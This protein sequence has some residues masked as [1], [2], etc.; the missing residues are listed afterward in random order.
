MYRAKPF[1]AWNGKL[2]E[3]ELR[4][5]VRLMSQMGFGGFFMHSRCGLD[6]KY[7]SEEW[8]KCINACVDEAE[9][10]DMQAWLYDEDR[11]P[12][13][14]AGGLVTKNPEYRQ[15]HLK[16][17][18]FHDN[19]AFTWSG[20]T[21][22]VFK[23]GL[24]GKKAS[25]I[26]RLT[27]KSLTETL[28]KGEA[29]LVFSV[30]ISEPS[31]WYNGYTYLDTLS[32][33]AVREFMRVTHEAYRKKCGKYFGRIPGI[34]T[35]EPGY[36][37]PHPWTDSLPK[38][39]K[40]RYGYDILDHLPELFYDL[41]GQSVSMAKYHYFDC[42]TFLFVNAFA[43]QIGEWCDKNKLIHTGHV[44]DEDS[45]S[46]QTA[47]C[48]SCMRFYEY[49]QAPGMDLVT[50]TRRIYDA[51]KQVSSAARQFGRKWRLTETYG[52]TGWDFSF[53]GHKAL[54]DWQAALGINL[55]CLHLSFY[56]MLGEAKRDHPASI[57]YQST[58]W[59]DYRKVEDYFARINV[60][61]TKGTEIRDLLVIHPVES[62]WL[63]Y[64]YDVKMSD[65]MQKYNQMLFQLRDSLLKE[66]ID[67]DYG[68]EDIL[69][70][71][72]KVIKNGSAPCLRV[73]QAE[74]K[75]V[76]VPPLLTI[77]AGTLRLLRE[78]KEAGGTLVF[79]KSPPD[80]VDAQPSGEARQLAETCPQ[81]SAAGKELP[82]AIEASSRR[83][84]ILDENGA[85]IA[86]ALY[87][88][89]EDRESFYLFVI[90]SG[91]K[92]SE[93]KADW[94]NDIIV[95]DRKA[96]FNRVQIITFFKSEQPL[97]LDPDTGK[98]FR[99]E[100]SQSDRGWFIQARLP[101]LGSKLYMLPKE[102][103]SVH[104][105]VK[106][107]LTS[108][109]QTPL[110]VLKWD[111]RLSETN[112]MALDRARYKLNS[113]KWQRAKDI[114]RVDHTVRDALNIPRRGA[115]TVQP[116]AREKP[117]A[118][119]TLNLSLSYIFDVQAVP[120]GEL[121]LGMELPKGYRIT[122]NGH[123]VNTDAECGWWCD[124]SLRK[125]PLDPNTLQVG[126]NELL[127]TMDYSENHPG[128]EMIYLLGNFG[129]ELKD[130]NPVMTIPPRFLKIGDWVPQGL[131]FYSGSLSYVTA[132]SSG[133][134]KG[135]R[136]FLKIPE[137]RGV[138]VKVWINGNEVG[139]IAWE[140]QEIDLTDF[141]NNG[142]SELRIEVLGHRRNS[143]G[144]LHYIEKQPIWTGPYEMSP[145]EKDSVEHYQ[146]V[147]CGLL[148]DPLLEVR[149]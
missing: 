130:N 85:E 129:V 1:W 92:E 69:A 117:E 138:A 14:A 125:I 101:A 53:S 19:D 107:E 12:S 120:G 26:I 147:P 73:G 64:R 77:R 3:M 97:E 15:R 106:K 68:D 6:T 22:A 49:M 10:L 122:I 136:L 102:K 127:F 67:F 72:G 58:W 143:H 79:T 99:A 32:H 114:L 43:R 46:H 141:L 100:A 133:L 115:R 98:V 81:V 113:S 24:R 91:H 21:L 86:P 61:M 33:K 140:P 41:E 103:S 96:S 16:L 74:Y 118:P 105:P 87:L 9:K 56:S 30:E 144:P 80:Y 13:G 25:K 17:N 36:G 4:R 5:Q 62:M 2:E 126:K 142:H 109:S 134:K 71:H 124:K 45:L 75:A 7:L 54:G 18:V 78:F 139:I 11:W 28:Q 23:A 148:A 112:V 47:G 37:W 110:H 137:Y 48:G 42:L 34:F 52:C 119:K 55:R 51:A 20:N 135:E 145:S 95:S 128:L 66:N 39:F 111:F 149:G 116:W 35:D 63:L 57:F 40:K 90:N 108:I 27:K 29:L 60:V 82:G 131:P 65:E 121:F 146:L 8:F 44:V 84:S 83:I 93:L 31:S 94:N 88:L 59:K 104:Y 132:L 76:I 50:E 123:F 38:E 89:R 70:R